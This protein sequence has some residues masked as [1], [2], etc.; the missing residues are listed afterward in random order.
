MDIK[1]EAA[2]GLYT[3]CIRQL[4][5]RQEE[6]DCDKR[7]KARRSSKINND[8]KSVGS[9]VSSHNNIYGLKRDVKHE[10]KVE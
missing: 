6:L 5:K 10:F 7:L 1:T 8:S 2:I 4:N 3:S 9:S